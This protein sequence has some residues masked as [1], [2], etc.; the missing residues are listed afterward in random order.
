[1][2][3]YVTKNVRLRIAA[4]YLNRLAALGSRKL[5]MLATR[6]KWG[7]RSDRSVERYVTELYAQLG[8]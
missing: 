4:E 5:A 3:V 2:E 8:T 1:M 7:L 6:K